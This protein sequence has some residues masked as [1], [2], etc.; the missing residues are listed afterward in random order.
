VAVAVLQLVAERKLTLDDRLGAL[1]PGILPY[2]DAITVRQLLSHTAGVPEFLD[3]VAKR[4]AAEPASW[5]RQWTPREL[6]ALVADQ[7]RGDG[8]HYSNT[9]FVLLGMVVEKVTG[10]SLASE[11]RRRI[12]GPLG[13]RDTT[14]PGSEL[15]PPEPAMHGYVPVPGGEPVDVTEWNP[16]A[17]WAAGALVSTMAD[18]ARFFRVLL[19]GGLLPRPLLEQMLTTTDVD[20]TTYGLGIIRLETPCGTVWGHNGAVFGYISDVFTRPDGSR[21]VVLVEN[22][23]D[24]HVWHVQE[25]LI[26]TLLCR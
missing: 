2:A 3:V 1:L 15:T 16:S 6:V 11:L 5:L 13:L 21:Q 23:Y 14:L 18:L 12:I 8:G 9:G 26:G 24:L 25:S 22:S 19:T 17:V 7:P 10:R 4:Y 20:G